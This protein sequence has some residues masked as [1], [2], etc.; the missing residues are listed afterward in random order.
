MGQCSFFKKECFYQDND[1]N[2][3]ISKEVFE[4]ITN[5]FSIQIENLL[6][7]TIHDNNLDEVE[8]IGGSSRLIFFRKII[9]QI[10]EKH[11]KTTLNTDETICEGLNIFSAIKLPRIITKEYNIIEKNN[12]N[13]YILIDNIKYKLFQKNEIL[14]CKQSFIV[15]D[16]NFFLL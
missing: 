3:E 7:K 6:T 8:I 12:E 10:T 4:N 15:K 14:P 11:V 13:I 16:K 1:V 2:I 5:A 9:K